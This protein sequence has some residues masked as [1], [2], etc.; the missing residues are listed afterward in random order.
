MASL[1]SIAIQEAKEKE[2]LEKQ[3]KSLATEI[4]KLI[5]RVSSLEKTVAV[6]K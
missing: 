2:A 4:A 6:L 3:L 5:K 1:K